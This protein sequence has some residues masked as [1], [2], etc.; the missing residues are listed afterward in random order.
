MA[1]RPGAALILLCGFSGWVKTALAERL[2]GGVPAVRL[3]P[4]AWMA[5]LGIGLFDECMRGRLEGWL[6]EHA[7][8]LLRLGRAVILEFGFWARS[9]RDEKRAGARAL[10]VSVELH[11]LAAPVDGLCRRLEAC[12]REGGPGTVPV[13]RELIEEYVKLFQAPGDDEPALF[14]EPS[15][16]RRG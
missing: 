1:A 11:C 15:L 6:W 16:G 3:C 12:S 9:E 2:A 5:A 13:G 7:R 8:E 10:G 4:D 14:G